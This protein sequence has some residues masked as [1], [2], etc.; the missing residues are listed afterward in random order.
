V[1]DDQ[2]R[3]QA[4]PV[5]AAAL[6]AVIVAVPLAAGYGATIVAGHLLA[7][8]IAHNRWW[9]V[10]VLAISL[11]TCALVSRL[12][13]RLLPL[14]TLLK[15]SMLFPEV[16][17]NRFRLARG[18]AS[19]TLLSA[20]IAHA[21]NSDAG[22]VAEAV[23][24]LLNNLTAHDRRT[25][26]H[27]ERVRV[28]VDLLAEQLR[29]PRESR[30]KLRWAALLHDIGKLRVAVDILNKPAKLNDDEFE[31]VAQHP[32]NGEAL[33]GPL[34]EWLGEWGTAVRQHH[35]RF[36]GAGYPDRLAGQEISRA[37]RIVAIADSY[38]VMTA[39]R[40][41]KKPM[42]TVAARSELVRCA[43][44]QF[45]PVY[46][47]AFLAISLPRLLWAM[48]PGSLL[49]NIP[50]LRVLAQTTPKALLVAPQSAAVAAVVV[51]G[52]AT[53][54]A[55]SHAGLPHGLGALH[56]PPGHSHSSSPSPSG[57]TPAGRGSV[58]NSGGP[59]GGGPGA[60]GP[61]ATGSGATGPG[62]TGPGAGPGA[63]GAVGSTG[64]AGSPGVPGQPGVPSTGIGA[65]PG[66]SSTVNQPGPPVGDPSSSS[67]PGPTST[68]SSTPPAPPTTP[69]GGGAPPA[70]TTAPVV[71]W[72]STPP[73]VLATSAGSA[74]FDVD[75]STATSWCAIDGGTHATCS[76]TAAFSGLA[77]G[78]HT[79]SVYAVDPAGNQSASISAAFRVATAAPTLVSKPANPMLLASS[80]T[81]TWTAVS[82]LTYQ[83]SLD[84]G[85]TWKTTSANAE[86]TIS[87][88]ALKTYAFWLRGTDSQG[89]HTATTKYSF[90][91]VL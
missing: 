59:N 71:T 72:D 87:T 56:G 15:L 26:G 89:N 11:G 18:S 55:A 66:G 90:T 2:N 79:I 34:V 1:A 63:S 83:Y 48:G 5:L 60:T 27:C 20:R 51:G 58:P 10:A 85:A 47:R 37:A 53:T 28:F 16:A 17:P 4:R 29:L 70:D 30:D 78:T 3:W 41:Y 84:S 14:A 6:R 67:N 13:R 50:M 36:D 39:H 69:A 57:S 12:T 74:T 32:A 68:G 91:V 22:A 54:G 61:G 76:G 21:Q 42:A 62:A 65:G 52:L 40:A 45:D 64:A 75:D 73:A 19:T 46:V 23:L 49:M 25:R 38:E 86:Q 7:G 80:A 33:L 8:R 88:S 43:G 77:D 82:G 31:L 44:A 35:E 24:A 81:V 9:V